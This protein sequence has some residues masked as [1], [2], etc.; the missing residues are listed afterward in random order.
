MTQTERATAQY[1]LIESYKTLE[2]QFYRCYGIRLL[3]AGA[4]VE[5]EDLS[6][7]R[8]EVEELVQKCNRLELSPLHFQDVLEDFMNR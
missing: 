3:F 8:R 4:S 1:E 6:M 2:E 5:V 7:D